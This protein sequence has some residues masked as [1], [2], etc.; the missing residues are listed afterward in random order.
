MMKS[1]LRAA[2]DR[3]ATAGLPRT[4]PTWRRSAMP[5]RPQ[6]GLRGLPCR[7]E[8]SGGEVP[9]PDRRTRRTGG[10]GRRDRDGQSPAGRPRSRPRSATSLHM[11]FESDLEAANA[12]LVEELKNLRVA[13]H[14]LRDNQEVGLPDGRALREPPRQDRETAVQRPADEAPQSN[15]P[16]N[17]PRLWWREG[18]HQRRPMSAAL[19]DLEQFAILNEVHGVAARRSHPLPCGPGDPKR[20]GTAGLGRALLRGSDSSSCSPTSVSALR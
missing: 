17:D 20:V 13:R 6:G 9:R 14:M 1:G 8:R 18:R 2:G 10:V 11:D 5:G 19:F 15:R 4:Q 7:A 16:R 12:R 3:H